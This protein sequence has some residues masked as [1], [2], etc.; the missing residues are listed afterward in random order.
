MLLIIEN[1][2][3]THTY[4]K[5]D[6]NYYLKYKIYGTSENVESKVVRESNPNFNH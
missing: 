3:I 4:S 1:S 2:T 6:L 5:F